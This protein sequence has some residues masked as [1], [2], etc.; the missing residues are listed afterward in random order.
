MGGMS[1]SQDGKHRSGE[2]SLLQPRGIGERT[3]EWVGVE[4][5]GLSPHGA[6]VKTSLLRV[7]QGG[8]A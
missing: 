7:G 8:A 6:A 1:E 5:Q 3:A 2:S 4:R